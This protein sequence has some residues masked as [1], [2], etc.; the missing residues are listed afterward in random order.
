MPNWLANLQ[1]TVRSGMAT[2]GPGSGRHRYRVAE[3]EPAPHEG[4]AIAE[5]PCPHWVVPPSL[6]G[7]SPDPR[8]R[9]ESPALLTPQ[10]DFRPCPDPLDRD[11]ERG[12]LALLDPMYHAALCLTGSPASA[13]DLVLETFERAYLSF[14]GLLPGADLQVWLYRILASA[15]IG[16]RR[17]EYGLTAE[18]GWETAVGHEWRALDDLSQPVVMA[19]LPGVPQTTVGV[20]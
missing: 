9:M 2:F 20:P 15:Y 11:F 6:L 10:E 19:A 1:H 17:E 18:G 16:S 14:R 12:V 3:E 13:E 7:H 8:N 5:F 4:A